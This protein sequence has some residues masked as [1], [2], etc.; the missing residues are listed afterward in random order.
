[1][2]T[3]TCAPH[4]HTGDEMAHANSKRTPWNSPKLGT[5]HKFR[6]IGNRKLGQGT[7]TAFIPAD[8]PLLANAEIRQGSKV[9]CPS[10][11]QW[12]P[13]QNRQRLVFTGSV[14]DGRADLVCGYVGGWNET[15]EIRDLNG[16][17]NTDCQPYTGPE[18]GTAADPVNPPVVQIPEYSAIILPPEYSAK[19]GL[20]AVVQGRKFIPCTQ[21]PANPAR[22]MYAGKKQSKIGIRWNVRP[23]GSVA[24]YNTGFLGLWSVTDGKR[25]LTLSEILAGLGIGGAPDAVPPVV[26]PAPP[27]PPPVTPSPVKGDAVLTATGLRLAPDLVPLVAKVLVLT[28]AETPSKTVKYFASQRGD[29]WSTGAALSTYPLAVFQIFWK[30]EPP[31]RIPHHQGFPGAIKNVSHVTQTG[32]WNPPTTRNP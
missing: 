31:A 11:I 19:V 29:E 17:Q 28:H 7:F 14:P 25:F 15:F 24:T 23:G 8:R 5:D 32:K 27:T 21:D 12:A 16:A 1:M 2:T 20:V 6:Y 22:W 26:P 13:S 30:V 4:F 18:S 10:D 9:Y 3:F